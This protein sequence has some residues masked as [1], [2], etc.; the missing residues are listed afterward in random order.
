[1]KLLKL[2]LYLLLLIITGSG[3]TKYLDKGTPDQFSD[4]DFWTGEN[5]LRTYSWGFYD[6]FAGFGTG[7][8]S[9]F[10]FST[11]TDDQAA[12]SFQNF[13]VSAP[14][15]NNDWD[16]KFIR[17]ANIL[18]ERIDAVPISEEAQ[19]HWKGVARFFRAFD[20][21]TKVKTFG[22]VPWIG[23]SL[24]VSETDEIYKPRDSRALV[25]DSILEDI[26]FAIANL[27]DKSVEVN[28]VNKDVALALKS[29][30]GLFEGT[31]RKY[32]TE[33]NLPDA[34]KFLLASKNASEQLMKGP[35]TLGVYKDLYSS[36]DLAGNKEVILYKKYLAGAL[37]HSVIGFTNATSQM[38]GLN[39]SAVESYVLTDGLPITLS[40][41][42]QGDDNIQ[43][44]RANRDKRLL[45]T[46][47]TFLCYPG[48][49]VNSL[50]S[51]TGYRP[52]K[53]LQPLSAQLAPNNE[54]DAPL[55]WLAEILLNYAEATA[56]LDQLGKLSMSQGDLDKSVNLLRARA[57]VAK[58]ELSGAQGTAINGK[59]FIDT[60][61][62]ADVTSLIWEI[63]RERR[64]ELMMD[65]FRYQ[66]LMR[67]KKG[68]YLDNEKNPD[69]FLGAKVPA[70]SQIKRNPQG[71]LIVYS[72][73][74]AIRKFIYPK[75]YLTAVPTGQISLYPADMQASMQNPMW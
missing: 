28:A 70:N 46:I 18:L 38:H 36:M 6:L 52:S 10:Y 74:T 25:M 4:N 33:L 48:N 55:F 49:L 3:C 26:D 71:Y 16:W 56:E 63:R 43:K 45:V 47:D 54:T 34:D 61:K 32:H 57:G 1:M 60:K 72:S 35:Y 68:E 44:L 39:K 30:I 64:V 5:N 31:Y 13:A 17:K 20:Y 66:D 69:I 75:H 59:P 40:P 29:R 51:T 23:R 11:F 73:G 37:T 24:D 42:Y 27:R 7:T 12:A 2:F 9:D 50:N 22:N 8:N 21:F 67:W 53:F 14:A 62:D 65:G 15:T 19:K 41:L 58:L